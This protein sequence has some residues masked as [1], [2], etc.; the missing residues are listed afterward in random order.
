[1]FDYAVKAAIAWFLGF[2][3]FFEIYV[4]VP[5]AIAMGLDYSSAVLWTVLGNFLPVPL[6]VFFYGQLLRQRRIGPWLQKLASPRAKGLLDRYGPW[7]ILLATPWIGV[8]AVAVTAM[9]LGI[10]Q[11]KLL[12]FSLISI[13]LYAVALAGLIAIGIQVVQPES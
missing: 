1:M 5:A 7:F 9:A 12:L 6:I 10:D 3:P 11:R 8:W 2:F 4:A 13:S